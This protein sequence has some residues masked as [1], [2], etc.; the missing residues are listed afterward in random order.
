MLSDVVADRPHPNS[1]EGKVLIAAERAAGTTW[2]NACKTAKGVVRSARSAPR[3]DRRF[4]LFKNIITIAHRYIIE[5][6]V[7]EP[8]SSTIST[9]GIERATWTSS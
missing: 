7:A 6:D 3:K 1:R 4:E 5:A 8:S 9:W 2:C